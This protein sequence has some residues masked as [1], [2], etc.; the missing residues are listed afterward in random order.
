MRTLHPYVSLFTYFDYRLKR[1]TRFYFV[2]GQISLITLL[3]WIYYSK[4][5]KKGSEIDPDLEVDGG[6]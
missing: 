3:L 1:L 4:W 2:L 6:E 5:I